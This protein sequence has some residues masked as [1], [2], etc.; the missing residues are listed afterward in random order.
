[1]RLR[2]RSWPAVS[3]RPP[4]RV[5]APHAVKTAA[6]GCGCAALPHQSCRRTMRSSRYIVL[7]TKSMPI[8]TCARHRGRSG[9]VATGDPCPLVAHL[10]C[11]V[12]RVIHEPRNDRRLTHRLVAQE[13]ELVLGARNRRLAG[14]SHL[15]PDPPSA[16]YADDCSVFTRSQATPVPASDAGVLPAGSAGPFGNV[17]VTEYASWITTV[18]D[19]WH[20]RGSTVSGYERNSQNLRRSI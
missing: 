13:D 18:G 7:D 20:S 10:V 9:A 8:V 19:M 12:E 17:L 15:P 6:G 4:R 14:L 1:M 2:K 11:V 3:L 5:A 16:F